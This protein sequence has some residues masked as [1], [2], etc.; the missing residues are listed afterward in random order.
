MLDF[1]AQVIEGASSSDSF[2][3]LAFERLRQTV[4]RLRGD[5]N[6]LE[7]GDVELAQALRLVESRNGRLVAN[8]AGLLL[9]GREEVL[10]QMIPTHEVFF[11]VLDAQGNVKVNDAFHGPLIQVVEELENR[12]AARNEE[13]EVTVG[14]FRLPI[15]DRILRCFL[16][17][18]KAGSM[19]CCLEDYAGKQ[20]V[21]NGRNFS[22]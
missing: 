13:R 14:M 12:F 6:L 8:V 20:I 5:R 9:L 2:D 11:Q 21:V 18:G 1:S 17:Q 3:P 16:S 10:R 4:A 19:V 15:P 22:G 7:L